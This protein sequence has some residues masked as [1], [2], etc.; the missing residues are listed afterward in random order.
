MKDKA[1]LGSI[2]KALDAY[3]RTDD[4]IKF[5]GVC[6]GLLLV[7]IPSRL[8]PIPTFNKG[9]ML[10][11][12]TNQRLFLFEGSY[13]SLQFK[14]GEHRILLGKDGRLLP[15]TPVM[16]I[17]KL[18]DLAGWHDGSGTIAVEGNTLITGKV[19]SWIG[20][21]GSNVRLMQELLKIKIEIKKG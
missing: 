10:K 15:E 17:R 6:A 3:D 19:G 8:I 1:L 9:F 7:R 11:C 2:N 20:G 13:L 12:S 14:W 4:F 21:N 5:N 16:Q 18:S